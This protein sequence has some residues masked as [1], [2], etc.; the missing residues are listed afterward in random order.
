MN[1][2]NVKKRQPGGYFH[3]LTFDSSHLICRKTLPILTGC[4]NLLEK[5]QKR[6]TTGT[7][8][9]ILPHGAHELFVTSW[10]AVNSLKI[11]KAKMFVFCVF[12]MLSIKCCSILNTIFFNG[13]VACGD[14]SV[15]NSVSHLLKQGSRTTNNLREWFT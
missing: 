10:H 6:N 14:I 12:P 15:M 11:L 9:N 2:M 7:P 4:T 5:F 13:S 3:H 1:C 8:A